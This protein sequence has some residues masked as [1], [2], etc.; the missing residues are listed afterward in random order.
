MTDA[1]LR[2]RALQR[3]GWCRWPGC[4]NNATELAHL[5]SKGIGGRPSAQTLDNVAMMCPDHARISDG[6]YGSGGRAQ[7][8][9]EHRKL[10][11][12][13]A[14]FVPASPPKAEWAWWRAEALHRLL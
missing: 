11:E 9:R 12:A 10:W 4:P 7:Y 5:H 13:A 8:E 2:A 1:E 6:E 3:D 14:W